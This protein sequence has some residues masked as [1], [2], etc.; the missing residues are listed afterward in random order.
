MCFFQI[1]ICIFQV[2][3]TRSPPAKDDKSQEAGLVLTSYDRTLIVK[4]ISSEEV[5]DMHNILSEY[6]QVL[7]NVS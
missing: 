6:H 1:S 2:S 7:S 3:L 5:E 4:Q